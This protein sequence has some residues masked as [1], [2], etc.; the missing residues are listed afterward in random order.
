MKEKKESEIEK[1]LAMKAKAMGVEE[2]DELA[3]LE[4]KLSKPK[5]IIFTPEK[6]NRTA[7][8]INFDSAVPRPEKNSNLPKHI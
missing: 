5:K 2:L 3:L 6:P 8:V 1:K 7:L 4:E